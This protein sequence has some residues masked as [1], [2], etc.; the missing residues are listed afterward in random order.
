MDDKKCVRKKYHYIEKHLK[1]TMNAVEDLRD[2]AYIQVLKQITDHPIQENALK[3]WRF[4]AIL[5]SCFPPSSDLF[6]GIINYLVDQINTN[7]NEEI[8]KR[9]NYILARIIRTYESKRK[10]IPSEEEVIHIEV[11]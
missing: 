3:G 11:K 10:V 9:A 4:F 8:N 1:R 7:S 2:E 6:Y 5:S